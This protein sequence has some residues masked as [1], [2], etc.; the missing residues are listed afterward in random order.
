V[1]KQILKY[2][3]YTGGSQRVGGWVVGEVGDGD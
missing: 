3:E 1:K 2:R